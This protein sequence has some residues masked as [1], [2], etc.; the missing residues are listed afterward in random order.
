MLQMSV[1]TFRGHMGTYKVTDTFF[2]PWFDFRHAVYDII[3]LI[4][5]GSKINNVNNIVGYLQ[6]H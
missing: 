4:V 2:T 5:T 6:G 1:T 3:K